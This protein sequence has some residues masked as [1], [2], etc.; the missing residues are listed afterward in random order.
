MKPRKPVHDFGQRI[1]FGG[2]GAFLL[3][4]VISS[5]LDGKISLRGDPVSRAD[6]PGAFWLMVAFLC[7]AAVAVLYWAIWET[8]ETERDGYRPAWDGETQRDDC[9]L[10]SDASEPGP[11]TALEPGSDFPSET[12][13]AEPGPSIESVDDLPQDTFP[14]WPAIPAVGAGWLVGLLVAP[15]T[16]VALAEAVGG[17]VVVGLFVI[18]FNRELWSARWFWLFLI[19][20]AAAHVILIAVVPWP[21]EH[22]WQRGDAL[23]LLFDILVVV[24]LLEIVQRIRRRRRASSG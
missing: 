16:T 9:R 14:G 24:G 20:V 15:H 1:L 13:K 7:L 4:A 3:F 12:R 22:E 2:L 19:A 18:F 6:Q 21:A 17:S 23:F 11:E 10:E 8:R 5:A